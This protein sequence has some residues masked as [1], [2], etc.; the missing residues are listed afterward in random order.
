MTDADNIEGIVSDDTPDDSALPDWQDI[1]NMIVENIDTGLSI[2]DINGGLWVVNHRF[3]ETYGV[4]T[5]KN[6][7]G[8]TIWDRLPL[9]LAERNLNIVRE[10]ISTQ[11]TI[12]TEFHRRLKG[13]KYWYEII[14]IP[15]GQHF[16][17]KPCVLFIT[18]DVTK[19]K[20]IENSLR[21]REKQLRAV[22]EDQTELICR[23]LP[24]CTIT[25]A[26]Q[27]WCRYFGKT[28]KEVLGSSIM[29][30]I[31]E[32]DREKVFHRFCSLTAY[33][34]ESSRVFRTKVAGYSGLK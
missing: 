22:V 20:N 33:S 26:N 14:S 8:K 5:G 28:L 32:E 30:Y 15:F 11:K 10:C 6:R 34:G 17:G 23:F 29:R 27:A 2:I 7:T 21:E 9:K 4:K 31:P 3:A 13:Q 16:F 18:K 1:L 24:D 25:F 19:Y 12:L